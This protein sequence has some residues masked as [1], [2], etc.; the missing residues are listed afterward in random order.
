LLGRFVNSL[1]R[2]RPSRSAGAVPATLPPDRA[3]FSYFWPYPGALSAPAWQ[4]NHAVGRLVRSM[5]ESREEL[6]AD[7]RWPAFFP[8][9]ICLATVCHD[10][11]AHLEKVVGATIV[12]RFPYVLALSFCRQPLSP[13][14][15]VR[16]TFMDAL[17]ASGRAAIQ[18]IMPGEALARVMAAIANVPEDATAERFFATGVQARQAWSSAAPVLEPAYLVYECRLVKPA[19][20][21]E[22]VPI[23]SSAWKDSG[24]H[25]IYFLEIESISL[26]EEI[27]SGATPLWW[28]SLPTWRGGPAP[29][30]T[31]GTADHRSRVLARTSFIKPYSPDYAFPSSGTV[32]FEADEHRDGFAIKHLPPLPKGQLHVDNDQARWPCFFPSSLGMITVQDRNGSLGGLSCGSTT[33]VSRHP[34]TMA[35]CVSYAPI[36]E[37][38]APRA[39]LALFEGAD[40]FGCGLPIYR[41]DVVEAIVYLGSVSRRTDVHKI[42]CCGLTPRQLGSTIGFDELPVHFGCKIVDRVRLGTHLMLLG[43]VENVMVRPDVT[44]NTPLEWCPWAGRTAP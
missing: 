13:R 41:K 19:R 34:L 25:R 44:P 7:S 32:A 26:R 36:N 16:R 3:P 40:R 15:Y 31:D 38:Y 28:R 10:G 4:F 2:A 30:R 17:E 9:S 11:V 5:P 33:V 43:E 42:A 14:H 20:D 29:T 12:N 39:S 21:F 35:I 8:S 23:N 27:A 22:G 18:F 1:A 6:A 24:S 37:R